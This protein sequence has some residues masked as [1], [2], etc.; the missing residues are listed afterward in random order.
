ML[1]ETI[2]KITIENKIQ[3]ETDYDVDIKSIIETYNTQTELLLLYL[4][5]LKNDPYVKADAYSSI[6]FTAIYK[7]Y[8]S[9]YTALDLTLQGLY[10]AARIL[11]RNIYEFLIISKTIASRKD[12]ELLRKWNNGE[13]ISLN[14]DVFSR[15]IKPKSLEMKILWKTLCEYTHGTIYSQQVKLEYQEIKNEIKM[16]FVCLKIL[17]DINYHVMNIFAANASIQYY[18]KFIS[19]LH[20]IDFLKDKKKEIHAQISLIR[21]TLSEKPKRAVLDFIS[22]WEF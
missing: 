20:T 8:I 17:V 1:T 3:I 13:E 7:N 6:I 22:K 14:R 5:A 4:S 12:D 10:G 2:N 21:K 16:N 18:A 11:F 15:V 19:D 9:L